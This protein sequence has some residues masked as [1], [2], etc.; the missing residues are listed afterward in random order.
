[1]SQNIDD[2]VPPL[3][4]RNYIGNSLYSDSVKDFIENFDNVHVLYY[5]D[6]SNNLLNEI[7]KI[8]EFLNLDKI[9][10][11]N[12]T[13]YNVSGIPKNKM[14]YYLVFKNY[15]FKNTMKKL[16]PVKIDEN[17][18]MNA[19]IVILKTALFVVELYGV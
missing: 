3:E 12:N 14:I 11:I 4:Y 6:I 2:G 10:N 5:D 17:P 18:N 16:I 8:L 1:M 13:K 15:L 7:N 19:A 9:S